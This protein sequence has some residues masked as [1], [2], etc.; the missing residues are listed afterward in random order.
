M[1]TLAIQI[2]DRRT[3]F[4]PRETVTGEVSWQ[5]DAPPESAE[6]RLLWSTQGRGI[7]DTGIVQTIPFPNPQAGETRPFTLVL[8]E[9]PYSFSG[10]LITL[11]WTLELLVQPGDHSPS[12]IVLNGRAGEN[13]KPF[14]AN[15]SGAL[16]G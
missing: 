9:A 6:L 15:Q 16:A 1:P 3:A 7:T 5:L 13:A 2:R 4:S 10:A 14:L 11:T 8:P 12:G